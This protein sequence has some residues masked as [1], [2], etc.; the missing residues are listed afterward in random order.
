[1]ND[2]KFFHIHM[3]VNKIQR[4]WALPNW[5]LTVDEVDKAV[6][7]GE[8]E[9]HTIQM[10]T[11]RGSLITE[12]GY[13]IIVHFKNSIGFEDTFEITMGDCERSFGKEIRPAHNLWHMLISGGFDLS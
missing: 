12:D 5:K 8:S 11:L 7:N 2:E 3:Y 6:K 10:C 13:R 1:M 9:I 4:H